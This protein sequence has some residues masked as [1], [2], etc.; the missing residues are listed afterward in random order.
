MKGSAGRR[1]DAGDITLVWGDPAVW[2]SR[3]REE[4]LREWAQRPI[5]DRLLVVLG[6]VRRRSDRAASR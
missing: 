4:R 1:V 2:K 6:M 3:L 5:A